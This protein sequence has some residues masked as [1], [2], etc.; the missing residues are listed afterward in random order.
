MTAD[1]DYLFRIFVNLCR[2]ARQAL[3][4]AGAVGNG[5]PSVSITA[6]RSQNGVRIEVSDNGP[7]IPEP[8]RAQLFAA[9]HATTRIG[10]SGLGLAIAADLVRAHGGSLR[11]LPGGTGA[12]FEILLPDRAVGR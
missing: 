2:N 4:A 5:P 8:M 9:F 6:E 7:G 10:G 1:P 12:H 3:E 11:L